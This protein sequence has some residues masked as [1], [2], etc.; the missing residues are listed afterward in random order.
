MCLVMENKKLKDTISDLEQQII[1]LELN[2][3]MPTRMEYDD[4]D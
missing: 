4:L 3:D 2:D 1:E